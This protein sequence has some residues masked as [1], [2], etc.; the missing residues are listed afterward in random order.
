VRIL[1]D[2]NDPQAAMRFDPPALTIPP[3]TDVRF[4]NVGDLAHTATD[5][6]WTPPGGASPSTATGGGQ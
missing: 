5:V 6:Q 2:A 4:V 1:G 3:G